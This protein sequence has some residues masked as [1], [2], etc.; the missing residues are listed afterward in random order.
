MIRD[1]LLIIK[2][3]MGFE[4]VGIRLREGDDF[5]YYETSGFPDD[6][7]EKERYLCARNEAGEVV[8]DTKGDPV[9]ECMC[10]G[11]LCGRTDPKFPFFTEGGS[12]WVNSTTK[13]LA[14]STEEDRQSRTRKYCHTRGYESVALIPLRSGE[15]IIGLLQC[16][17]HRHNQFTPEM[18]RFFEGLSASIGIALSRKRAEENLMLAERLAVLGRL[19]ATVGHEIRNP[20]GTVSSS[21][22]SVKERVGGQDESVDRALAR[23]ERGIKRCDNIIEDLLSYTRKQPPNLT[24]TDLDNWLAGLLDEVPIPEG[25]QLTRK[26]SCGVEVLIDRERLRRGVIN[27]ID[28]ACQAMSGSKSNRASVLTVE[29]HV[30]DGRVQ[31]RVSDTGPGIPPDQLGKIFEPLYSTKTFG[32]GLGLPIVKQILEQHAGGVEVESRESEGTLVTLW[33]P[34][35]EQEVQLEHASHSRCR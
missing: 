13:L 4:A 5:P 1:I 9:L 17:D 24:A 32:V 33:L 22:F 29:T 31:I 16:N 27:V 10:G 12:F 11:V 15:E 20:L 19:I 21:I 35:A 34:H 30:S 28:N 2:K 18:I 6:F 3:S 25:I 14:S 7:V 26:L 23:A 8:R